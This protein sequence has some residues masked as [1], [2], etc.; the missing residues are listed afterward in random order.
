MCVCLRG[1]VEPEG[2]HGSDAGPHTHHDDRHIRLRQP[3]T[4]IPVMLQV[5][6]EGCIYNG[7]AGWLLIH[8]PIIYYLL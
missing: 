8:D 2:P 6:E 3:E 1:S 7:H 4:R 5:T